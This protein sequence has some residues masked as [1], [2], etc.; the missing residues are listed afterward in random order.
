M[1]STIIHDTNGAVCAQKIEVSIDDASGKIS[2]VTFYGGC[3][4]N[5]AG[6]TSLVKGMLPEEV[7]NRLTG[8]RCGGRNSSCPDQL[9]EALKGALK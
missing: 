4:G 7:V 9:A 1:M 3:P 6:L 8:I 2:D 5:H